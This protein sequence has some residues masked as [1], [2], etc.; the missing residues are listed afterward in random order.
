MID[1]ATKNWFALV[2]RFRGTV[3]RRVAV[4]SGLCGAFAVV[5]VLLKKQYGI[6]VSIPVVVHSII[7]VALG[8]LLVFRTNA[9]Y[10]RYWAGRKSIA[11]LVAHCRDLARQSAAYLSTDVPRREQ[12]GGLIIAFFA[13]VR[14]NLRHEHDFEELKGH[15]SEARI[16][17]LH[18]ATQPPLLVASWLTELFST[19]SEDGVLSEQRLRN[20]DNNLTAIVSGWSDA[21]RIHDTPVPFAYAHHIKVFLT[22]FCFTVPFALVHIAD[23]Y[24]ITGASVVA[25]GMFGI[26]EIGVEIEDPFG[27]DENDLPLDEIG[28]QLEVDIS[29][30]TSPPES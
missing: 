11:D 27:Y 21:E 8:L 4:R 22:L 9:S 13:A 20:V 17:A 1:Y 18:S 16:E 15:V 10:D 5:A 19:A 2:V 26:D 28:S 30:I 3:L 14:R 25:F 29:S 24:A 12:A 7:G 23:W 6:D